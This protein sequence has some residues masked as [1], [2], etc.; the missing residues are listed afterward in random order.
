[1][2]TI[3]FD[4]RLEAWFPDKILRAIN[5]SVF[6][7]KKL[8]LTNVAF[9]LLMGC[10]VYGQ[11]IKEIKRNEKAAENIKTGADRTD[12]YLPLLKGKSVA[13]VANPTSLI[14]KNHL[15]DSLISLGIKVKKV[16]F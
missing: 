2:R 7:R 16:F 8:G 5:N 6:I 3:G 13:V 12:E 10:A 11:N 4:I 14:G 9:F 1:M 15:V